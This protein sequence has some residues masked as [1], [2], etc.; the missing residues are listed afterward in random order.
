M[1]PTSK[2]PSGWSFFAFLIPI[3]LL[4][5]TML[6]AAAYALA[7]SDSA[8]I[9]CLIFGLMIAVAVVLW[10]VYKRSGRKL[11]IFLLALPWL[12]LMFPAVLV[13]GKPLYAEFIAKKFLRS[14]NNVQVSYKPL[15]KPSPRVLGHI[16]VSYSVPDGSTIDMPDF[17][18]YVKNNL[19]SSQPRISF[20]EPHFQW[21]IPGEAFPVS[22]LQRTAMSLDG[23]TV[24]ADQSGM[25]FRRSGH[26][27]I[28]YEVGLWNVQPI[29][30][31]EGQPAMPLQYCLRV[32]EHDVSF[33]KML[34][35]TYGTEVELYAPVKV[36]LSSRYDLGNRMAGGQTTLFTSDLP[37][38]KHDMLALAVKR[39]KSV[40]LP[41][42]APL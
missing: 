8:F 35:N 13:F 5:F 34:N 33:K 17:Q 41:S 1:N 31:K 22:I 11:R 7:H 29:L 21:D 16:T 20:P 23:V 42:C 27:V 25:L 15:V 14:V 26:Y 40:S 3:L 2:K 24:P 19:T 18:D 12:I 10:W 6:S 32:A 28:T 39:L 4:L 37:L 36:I 9:L 30:D 38:S